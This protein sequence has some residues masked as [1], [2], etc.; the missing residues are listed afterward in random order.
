MTVF[1]HVDPDALHGVAARYQYDVA[2][3]LSTALTALGQ[4]SGIERS[5][6]TAVCAPLASV[7][8]EAVNFETREL[9][10]RQQN[11]STFQSSLHATADAWAK[12]EQANTITPGSVGC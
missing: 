2:P 5:N 9:Q 4:T 12:A 11:A 6:F 3:H 7:Y 8:V 10:T 1:E